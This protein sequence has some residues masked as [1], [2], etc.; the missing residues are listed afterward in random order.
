MRPVVL[1]HGLMASAEAMSHAQGWIEADFPGI[2]VCVSAGTPPQNATV[3]ALQFGDT[4]LLLRI[5]IVYVC[6]R[7]SQC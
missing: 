2:Y 4:A 6:M 3:E 7:Q 1:L 5:C